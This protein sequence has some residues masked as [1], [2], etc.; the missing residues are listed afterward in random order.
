MDVN[1]AILEEADLQE[2][3]EETDAGKCIV[4]FFFS[5]IKLAM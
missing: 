2:N 5:L 4:F 1:Q 3:K